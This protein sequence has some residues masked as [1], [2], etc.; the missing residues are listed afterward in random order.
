MLECFSR[1]EF[2]ASDGSNTDRQLFAALLLDPVL[3]VLIL[4]STDHLHRILEVNFLTFAEIS[5]AIEA[6]PDTCPRKPVYLL[7]RTTLSRYDDNQIDIALHDCDRA[8]K[9]AAAKSQPGVVELAKAT[10]V[11]IL[12]RANRYQHATNLAA[13][14]DATQLNEK[15]RKDF[16]Q[17]TQ[18]LQSKSN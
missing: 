4:P 6:V 14:V 5:D 12:I 11:G 17:L 10:Q 13:T 3:S 18:F 8:I 1:A 16:I 7:G 2:S 9:L 15:E